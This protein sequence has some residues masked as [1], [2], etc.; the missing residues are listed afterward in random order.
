[1]TFSKRI[2]HKCWKNASKQVGTASFHSLSDLAI[3]KFTYAAFCTLVSCLAY[4]ST[5]KMEAI[6]SSEISVDFP[7]RRFIPEDITVYN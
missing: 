2:L 5:L 4:Y 3:T 1:V 6:C 7:T